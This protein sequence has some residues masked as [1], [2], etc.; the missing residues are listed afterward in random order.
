MTAEKII[1]YSQYRDDSFHEIIDYQ[2]R[3]GNFP[4]AWRTAQKVKEKPY[5]ATAILKV[6]IAYAR[7]QSTEKACEVASGIELDEELIFEVENDNSKGFYYRRPETWGVNYTM[8]HA[9]TMSSHRWTERRAAE[10]AEH[11]M[12]LAQTL[13]HEHENN[14]AM[15]FNDIHTDIIIQALARAHSEHGNP[16]EA[17]SW[18]LQ[19]G[20]DT[21]FP[22]SEFEARSAIERR[23]YA[24]IGVTEGILKRKEKDKSDQN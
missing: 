6:A 5:K 20:S 24:L 16:Q 17:I 23:I 18:V 19:V 21:M 9:F 2:I 13:P 1:H 14:Y 11:A 10:V 3:K 22:L 8:G 15:D 7:I 4:Q 12:T